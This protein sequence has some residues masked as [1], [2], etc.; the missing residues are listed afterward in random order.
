VSPEHRANS[1]LADYK[2]GDSFPHV[3]LPVRA[4]TI[5]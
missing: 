5:V 3:H 1:G 4:F 2:L